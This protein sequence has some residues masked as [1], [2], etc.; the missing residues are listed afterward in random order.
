MGTHQTPLSL[1]GSKV[2]VRA[3]ALCALAV[4]VLGIPAVHE[5]NWKFLYSHKYATPHPF[6]LSKG[7]YF[8]IHF[9]RPFD[10][11]EHPRP[12]KGG[13]KCFKRSKEHFPFSRVLLPAF[14]MSPVLSWAVV[15][16]HFWPDLISPSAD[17][18]PPHLPPCSSH[19]FSTLE[20]CL[21]EC[22]VPPAAHTF[23]VPILTYL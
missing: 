16:P 2:R 6:S 23:P 8:L 7:T 3:S 21:E 18:S 19:F 9:Q 20:S 10:G 4:S 1:G 13:T 12:L 11:A 15:Q 17:F 22:L 5:R 14:Q